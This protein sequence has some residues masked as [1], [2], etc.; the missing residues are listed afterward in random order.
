M[1][2]KTTKKR[3]A[4]EVSLLACPRLWRSVYNLW[5]CFCIQY[6]HEYYYSG[7]NPVE[8]RG[9]VIYVIFKS[10]FMKFL[11]RDKKNFEK[12]SLFQSKK[13]ILWS[14]SSLQST[15]QLTL[16]QEGSECLP[17]TRVFKLRQFMKRS[18]SFA[19]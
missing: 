15:R 2:R 13:L 3:M 8:F 7:V 12:L 17:H 4:A 19:H 18:V 11:C 10:L 14:G 5:W 6:K 16:M 1:V 9:H